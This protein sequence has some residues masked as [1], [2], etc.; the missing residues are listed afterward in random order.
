[1]GDIRLEKVQMY[2]LIICHIL[3]WPVSVHFYSSIARSLY[4][5]DFR[6]F[7]CGCL[8]VVPNFNFFHSFTSFL[9]SLFANTKFSGLQ[10][11]KFKM[12]MMELCTS[13]SRITSRGL[14]RC[15]VSRRSAMLRTTSGALVGGT[16]PWKD[17]K[18]KHTFSNFPKHGNKSA[19][20]TVSAKRILYAS[21]NMNEMW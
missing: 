9:F 19:A 6:Y 18:K 5:W 13:L 20:E 15:P 16:H 11:N 14:W 21:Y 10:S 17:T 4:L 7:P 2:L 8:I 3:I 1:M 12:T